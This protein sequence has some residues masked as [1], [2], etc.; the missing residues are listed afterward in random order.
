ME[1]ETNEEHCSRIVLS[2]W[3]RTVGR[4][5]KDPIA[6]YIIEAVAE[7]L[8][9]HGPPT[10]VQSSIDRFEDVL[11]NS[12]RIDAD[13]AQD[14]CSKLFEAMQNEER[15]EGEECLQ[16]GACEICERCLPLTRH[17]LIPRTL[18]GRLRKRG[19]EREQLCQTVNICSLCHRAVHRFYSEKQ[20]AMEYNT[21]EKLLQVSVF[22]DHEH[23]NRGMG[24]ERGNCASCQ[25]GSETANSQSKGRTDCCQTTV[26]L[27]IC[28]MCC[29]NGRT[30]II[31]TCKKSR[32][33]ALS[34]TSVCHF[35]ES[36]KGQEKSERIEDDIAQRPRRYALVC[37]FLWLAL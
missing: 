13:D 20:L 3:R 10:S 14:F 33:F 29:F 11:A 22:S 32:R 24:L 17:H 5:D 27:G 7:D 9:T 25:M 8:A 1:K 34:L 15:D 26:I 37:S 36:Q 28:V 4:T 18:H 21:L 31:N 6:Q 19:Y 30:M 16:P 2:V 12:E 35:K 23:E